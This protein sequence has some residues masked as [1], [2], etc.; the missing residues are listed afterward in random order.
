MHD[1]EVRKLRV[2]MWRLQANVVFW[3]ILSLTSF[4]LEQVWSWG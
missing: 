1:V 3:I 4:P 2:A